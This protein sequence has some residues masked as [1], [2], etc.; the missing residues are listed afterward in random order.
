M[1]KTRNLF[2]K[3][4]HIREVFHAKI[5]MIKEREGKEL[6]E[7]E[8]TKKGWQEY[9]EEQYKKGLNDPETHDGVITH[10]E[11]DILA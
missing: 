3:I 9:T 10:L 5:D 8:D 4:G 11:P 7:A 1:A 6:T 2:K